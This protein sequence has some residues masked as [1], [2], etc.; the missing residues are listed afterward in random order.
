MKDRTKTL[1]TLSVNV[2]YLTSIGKAFTVFVFTMTNVLGNDQ[3]YGFRYSSDK[4]RRNM[5]GPM[6]PRFFYLGMFMSFGID[7]RQEQIDRQ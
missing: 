1:N 4:L 3:E 5:V 7:R 6:A 2:N